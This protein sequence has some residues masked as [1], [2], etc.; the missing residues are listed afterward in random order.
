M[1][2]KRTYGLLYLYIR[3]LFVIKKFDLKKLTVEMCI[4]NKYYT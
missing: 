3:L 4:K 2:T 1:K